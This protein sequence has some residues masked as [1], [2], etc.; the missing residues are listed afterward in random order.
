MTELWLGAALAVTGLAWI[1]R[2]VVRGGGR[3][4]PQRQRVAVAT[5]LVSL[6]A[7]LLVAP[8]LGLRYGQS[9][10]PRVVAGGLF[11]VL[12][13]YLAQLLPRV[14]PLLGA[15]LTRAPGAVFF[16]LPL[17]VYLAL[18][19][20][21]TKQRPPDGDEPYN[22]LVAH[23]LAYDLDADLTNNYD[24][25]HSRA[26]MDRA[27]APQKGDPRGPN[28]EYY[29]RHNV[30]LPMVLAP[31]YRLAG[32]HGALA[33]MCLFA[34]GLAWSMLRLARH[35]FADRPG[36]VLLAY[37]ILAFTSPL[38]LYSHQVWVEIPAALLLT[39][40]LDA[41]WSLDVRRAGRLRAWLPVL[42]PIA[43]LPLIKMRF[44]LVIG[45]LVLLLA[46]RLGRR[47][48][49]L[50]LLALAGCAALG[51]A[52]LTFNYLRYDN[53]LK[54][55]NLQHMSFYWNDPGRYP[56]G[57][58]GLFFDSAFGLFAT[59][60]IWLLLL[61]P[62]RDK[63]KSVAQL[64]WIMAPYLLMLAP[65]SEWY[66]GWSPPFRYGCV[67]LTL[68]ALILVPSLERRRN[69][70]A[71]LV[72]GALGA[73][74]VALNLLWV[75][76]PGWTY[77][78]SHG[79]T[80][81]VDFLSRAQGIDL[82]RFVPSAV[83]PNL[84]LWIWP[85]VLA[86]G[87]AL[88]WR[89]SLRRRRGLTALGACLPILLV[90]GTSLAAHRLPTRRVQVEDPYIEHRGG[91]LWPETW[92]VARTRFRG[93]WRLG[94]GDTLRVPLVPGGAWGALDLR[95]RTIGPYRPTLSFSA[96]STAPL[97]TSPPLNGRW[98]TIPAGALPWPAGRRTLE[99]TVEL[100]PE[101]GPAAAILI[102]HLILSW[103]D[104]AP[105][106]PASQRQ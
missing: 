51:L 66:G 48:R 86:V 1:E 45:P 22:L 33:V 35:F 15:R 29:S 97:V 56:R 79:R 64:A 67:A 49:R 7:L 32:K 18:M 58:V 59:S 61:A 52:I 106:D 85:I 100:P 94:S 60:P 44:V 75:T 47:S 13:A 39:L 87:V 23:S 84:A 3:R 40:A 92:V 101:A 80:H 73:A 103:S 43:I 99:L 46:W 83:R 54:Y 10:I 89:L 37:F 26:F 28:G 71:R 36:P 21:A 24:E 34:A 70:G 31:A 6:L 5:T 38:L 91:S 27:I 82:A 30:L 55:H 41:A 17:V 102:D 62:G 65:R 74:T 72:L 90:A 14:R 88:L 77:N 2:R 53:L 8:G 104:E 93:G 50:V 81:L 4:W 78:I 20:W 19:P 16:W 25:A 57:L 63:L 96:G 95:Y 76:R 42:I 68:F 11:L 105:V 9:L 98:T 12:L 69:G